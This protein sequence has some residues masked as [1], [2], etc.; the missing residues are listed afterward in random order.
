MDTWLIKKIMPNWLKKCREIKFWRVNLIEPHDSNR[1]AW[2]EVSGALKDRNIELHN[3]IME[4]YDLGVLSLSPLLWPEQ[5]KNKTLFCNNIS[6]Q[7]LFLCICFKSVLLSWKTINPAHKIMLPSKKFNFFNF[8]FHMNNLNGMA[9]AIV[10]ECMAS[11]GWLRYV[12]ACLCRNVY[13]IPLT[14]VFTVPKS[15]KK[16]MRHIM[17]NWI[18]KYKWL[19]TFGV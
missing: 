7:L 16:A 11:R 6:P 18:V 1:A 15:H 4:S 10:V 9:T 8:E 19:S 14:P 2:F 13:I 3:W 5:N 17:V 12:P